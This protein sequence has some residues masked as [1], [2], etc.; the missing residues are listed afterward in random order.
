MAFEI[1]LGSEQALAAGLALAAG[2]RSQRVET[3][4]NG[5]EKALLCLHIRG[6][7]P[8]QGWLCLVGAVRAAQALNGGVRLPA[9]LEQVVNPQST[10]SCRQLGMVA[11]AR[12]A[13]VG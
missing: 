11:P 9:G 6:D 4:G 10:I 8:E 3:A 1:V 2:N 13:R 12:T 5:R 7:R